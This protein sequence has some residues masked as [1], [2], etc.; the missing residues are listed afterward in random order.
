[1]ETITL[2]QRLEKILALDSFPEETRNH[3][4][5]GLAENILKRVGLDIIDS[6]SDKEATLFSQMTEKG[7]P[8]S[9]LVW[10]SEAHPELEDRLDKTTL[11]VLEEFMNTMKQ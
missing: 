1:M 4:I 9:A 8:E 3:I 6:L 11:E 5:A 10:L 7:S 2:T